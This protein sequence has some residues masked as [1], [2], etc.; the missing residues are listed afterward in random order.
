MSILD[1]EWHDKMA[2]LLFC[3]SS[4][5]AADDDR[6]ERILV[7]EADIVFTD[8]RECLEEIFAVDTDDIL[9]SLDR[10]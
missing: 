3:V 6:R 10:S 5:D 2:V 9:L 7:L 4:C 1:L 8:D